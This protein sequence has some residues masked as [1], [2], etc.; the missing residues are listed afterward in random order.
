VASDPECDTS[1]WFHEHKASLKFQSAPHEPEQ[2]TAIELLTAER[3]RGGPVC[4]EATQLQAMK[5]HFRNPST[6]SGL[7]CRAG[8]TDLSIDPEGRVRLCCFL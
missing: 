3:L 6:D 2:L 1:R 5:F 7:S 4:N 8:H